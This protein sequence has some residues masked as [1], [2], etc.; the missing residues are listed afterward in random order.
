MRSGPRAHIDTSVSTRTVKPKIEPLELLFGEFSALK[1]AFTHD[2]R[3]P[4]VEQQGS[5]P[6]D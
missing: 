1:T 2:N 3:V 6:M 5:S 4:K